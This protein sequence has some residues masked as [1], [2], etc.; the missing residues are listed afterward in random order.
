MQHLEIR[1]ASLEDASHIALLGR[2]TFEETFGHHFKDRQDLL[3]Y[4]D[5]TF[6]VSKI[7]KSI[8]KPN[9]VF[10][11]ALVDD[12]PVGYAKL[13]LHSPCEGVAKNAQCQ[14]QKIYVLK[15]FLSMKIGLSLQNQLLEKARELAFENIWLSVLHSNHR[16][17]SF[18]QKNGFKQIGTH[19]YSIG[20][21]DFDFWYMA[22]KL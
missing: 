4:F 15:D 20:K 14:L 10:W 16:A 7:Q 17:I 18:Y 22:K 5:R 11:L 13:K 12:L 21:E 6:S 2:I 1:L 9:T 3:D 19:Q 8:A